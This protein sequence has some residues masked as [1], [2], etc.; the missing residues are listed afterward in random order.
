MRYLCITLASTVAGTCVSFQWR[1]GLSKLTPPVATL[2]GRL[3]GMTRQIS[4]SRATAERSVIAMTML[5]LHSPDG[6]L[7]APYVGRT[8]RAPLS[9]WGDRGAQQILPGSEAQ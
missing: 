8:A 4:G 1:N 2:N 5:I 6:P 7:S 9:G 3:M